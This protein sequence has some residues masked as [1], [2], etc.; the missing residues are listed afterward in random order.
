MK[1]ARRWGSRAR[2]R[3]L[4]DPR[5]ARLVPRPHL[6]RAHRDG[7]GEATIAA[8]SRCSPASV[9]CPTT[10]WRRWRRRSRP[11]PSPSWSSPS[12]ARAASSSPL[13]ATCA[14]CARS[15][16]RRNLLLILDEIQTGMGR[17]GTLFA[18]EQAGVGPRRHG[19]RQGAR[20][21]RADR[22]DA[23]PRERVA[24]A[25]TPGRA[26]HHVRRQPARVRRGGRRA[27]GPSPSRT[28]SRTSDD[29]GTTPARRPR[30]ARRSATPGASRVRGVGLMLGAVLDGP[31]ADVVARCLDA[32]PA[33]QLHGGARAAL[34]AAAHHHGGRD[35]RRPRHPRRARSRHGMKRDLLRIARSLERPRSRAILDLAARLKAD[36]RAQP[37]ASAARRPDAGDDLREAEP[38]HAGHLRGRHGAA[39]RRRDQPRAGRHHARR[40]RVGAPTSRATSSAGSICIMARVF[41]HQSVVDLARS[42]AGA[43][44]QRP[45]RP[46]PSL[47]GARGLLHAARASRPHRGAARRLR[48]RRQQHGA[49]LDGRCRAGSASS[50][51]SP[52]R[53]ATS[54]TRRSPPRP[55]RSVTMTHDVERGRA[56]RRRP[57][58]RRLDQH[59]TGAR[60]GRAPPTCVPA[61]PGERARWS[62]SPGRTRWSCTACPRTA[63]RRSPTR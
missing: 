25:F 28:C 12:R 41:L 58:H 43:G 44:H 34:H 32:R 47:P 7:P 17:T 33:H 46:P 14:A 26:R 49:L 15:A 60:G 1:L 5:H 16:D 21:R 13:R 20:R 37:P 10:T 40:A 55:A 8:T 22:R 56:R 6:R 23:A 39:R 50:S 30:G 31:G 11:R 61:V 19:A 36:L 63:A 62:R 27:H 4:R 42:A 2:R 53:P 3:S 51:C 24:A 38:A 48:R 9:S 45:L 35:R 29:R 52:A 18:Y 57:L 59:G 54:P